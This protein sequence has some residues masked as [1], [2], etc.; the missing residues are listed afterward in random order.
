M[1]KGTTE[2]TESTETELEPLDYIAANRVSA[3]CLGLTLSSITFS[4]PSVSSV[5][6]RND[7]HNDGY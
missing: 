5:V 4:V 6:K 3:I 7:R 1:K 2:D